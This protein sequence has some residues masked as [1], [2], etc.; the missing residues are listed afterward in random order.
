MSLAHSLRKIVWRGD[1]EPMMRF[2]SFIRRTAIY[3]LSLLLLLAG[4]ASPASAQSRDVDAKVSAPKLS[5][6]P[7]KLNFGNQPANSVGVIAMI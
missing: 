2:E 7:K 1:S 5:I 6:S 3:N 4:L